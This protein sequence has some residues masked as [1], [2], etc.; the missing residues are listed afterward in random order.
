MT[1]KTFIVIDSYNHRVIAGGVIGTLA[2]HAQDGHSGTFLV[3]RLQ[4]TEDASINAE[5]SSSPSLMEK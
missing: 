5:C 2:T 4:Q 1:E 3:A